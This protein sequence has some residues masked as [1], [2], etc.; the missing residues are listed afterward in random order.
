M[1]KFRITGGRPLRGRLSIS[2]AKNSALPCM[3]A[4]LL[5][6]ETITLHNIPYVRDIITQRRLLE[7]DVGLV[8]QPQRPLF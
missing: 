1:D 2:G 4:A 3:A 6:S 5:T 7:E 8:L